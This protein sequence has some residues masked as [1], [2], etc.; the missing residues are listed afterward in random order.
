MSGD[1]Y[2]NIFPFHHH[3]VYGQVAETTTSPSLMDDLSALNVTIASSFLNSTTSNTSG[4]ISLSDLV[5]IRDAVRFWV[6][7][8]LVPLVTAIGL[9]GNLLTLVVMCQRRMTISTTYIYMAA[10][11]LFDALYLVFVFLLSLVHYPSIQ[12]DITAAKLVYWH[13]YPALIFGCDFASNT[14]IWLTV[15]FTVER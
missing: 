15:C 12:T 7:R 5:L 14:S 4:L 1:Y 6:Q 13:S 3:D 9:F 2:H 11:A 8:F 10:L